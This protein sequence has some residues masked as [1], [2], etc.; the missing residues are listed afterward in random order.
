MIHFFINIR[1]KRINKQTPTCDNDMHSPNE[2]KETALV[3][4]I[5]AICQGVFLKVHRTTSRR[6]AIPLSNK[7]RY[8]NRLTSSIG[9]FQL[10][11]EHYVSSRMC[12]F[13]QHNFTTKIRSRESLHE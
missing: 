8:I 2:T 7:E 13:R 5:S 6:N 9:R 3:L 10:Q 11:H 4:T 1:Y 12:N